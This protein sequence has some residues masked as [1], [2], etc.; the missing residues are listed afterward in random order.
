MKYKENKSI[1]EP[2][3][4]QLTE[5][6]PKEETKEKSASEKLEDTLKKIIECR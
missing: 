1:E 2:Q 5:V 4:E 6:E 3:E